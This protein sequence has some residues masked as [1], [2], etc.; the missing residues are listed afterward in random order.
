M[1][2]MGML[3]NNEVILLETRNNKITF[4]NLETYE[5]KSNPHQFMY[6]ES[7]QSDIFT[8]LDTKYLCIEEKGRYN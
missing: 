7:D 6:E 2:S 8:F 3:S 4:L 5:L 1:D